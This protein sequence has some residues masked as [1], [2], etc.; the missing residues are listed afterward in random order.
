MNI[1]HNAILKMW[2][3]LKESCY[4]MKI[5]SV[6]CYTANSERFLHHGYRQLCKTF[7]SWIIKIT[8]QSL[9]KPPC[10]FYPYLSYFWLD[11]LYYFNTKRSISNTIYMMKRR[12][13]SGGI[14]IFQMI[15][16][17][18]IKYNTSR[19]LSIMMWLVFIS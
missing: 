10:I 14:P 16:D 18:S 5:D 17:S 15:Y 19:L 13:R 7:T 2:F 11:L 8:V 6:K 9:K 12:L 1:L 4:W 3:C